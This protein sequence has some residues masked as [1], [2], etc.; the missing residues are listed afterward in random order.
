MTENNSKHRRFHS[1]NEMF[2]ARRVPIANRDFIRHAFDDL[3]YTELIETTN[4]VKV[5]LA[6]NPRDLRIHRGIIGG[7]SSEAEA[8]N[9]TGAKDAYP[10]ASRPGTWYVYLPDH[11]EGDGVQRVRKHAEPLQSPCPSCFILMDASGSCSY[12]N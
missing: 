2:Q 6:D 5:I 10:S 8:L 12:C 4:Y 9:H 1:F 11:G 3:N 7:Y